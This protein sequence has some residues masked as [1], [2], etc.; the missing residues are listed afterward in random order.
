[1]MSIPH[2]HL[3]VVGNKV[4]IQTPASIIA[5][6]HSPTDKK[7]NEVL[8]LM[9]EIY[10]KHNLNFYIIVASENELGVKFLNVPIPSI[11]AF[12]KNEPL[13]YLVSPITSTAIIEF[14]QQVVAKTTDNTSN[15][16]TET[17]TN[18]N[19]LTSYKTLNI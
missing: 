13:C 1:M 2:L 15:N 5:L 3:T 14:W 10:Q 17:I 9:K 7:S 6:I 12:K 16:R 8:L 11:V 18:K 19:C 4:T